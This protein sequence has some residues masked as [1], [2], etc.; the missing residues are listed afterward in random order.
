M[1]MKASLIGCW[2]IFTSLKVVSWATRT[3]MDHAMWKNMKYCARE[4][5]RKLR[6]FLFDTL[7]PLE[8]C[9]II[10]YGTCFLMASFPPTESTYI[11]VGRLWNFLSSLSR[12]GQP[13]RQAVQLH[14][15]LYFAKPAWRCSKINNANF[16]LLYNSTNLYGS[17]WFWTKD[18]ANLAAPSRD[19][20][21]NWWIVGIHCWS[22]YRRW[23]T[24]FAFFINANIWSKCSLKLS[25]FPHF[26]L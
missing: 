12:V 17:L 22:H 6:T 9:I 16:L 4:W 26:H 15:K 1:W 20:F 5:C 14:V 11:L 10:W 25:S 8:R 3:K 23:S 18:T 7:V 2:R 13:W 19:G 21:F 24:C